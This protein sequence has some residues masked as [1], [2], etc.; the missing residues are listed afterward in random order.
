MQDAN[1]HLIPLLKLQLLPPTLGCLWCPL[2]SKSFQVNFLGFL[3]TLGIE[4][5]TA[6]AQMALTSSPGSSSKCCP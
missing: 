5:I 4:E 1:F 3:L 2:H 6:E